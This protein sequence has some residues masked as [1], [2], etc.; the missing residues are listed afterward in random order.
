[1]GVSEG[2]AS[3]TGRS[4]TG[5]SETGRSETGASV[6]GISAA[7]AFAVLAAVAAG[8][9]TTVVDR[10]GE[11]YRSYGVWTS[12]QVSLRREGV[13]GSDEIAQAMRALREA[14]PGEIGGFDV[15]EVRDFATGAEHRPRYLGAT[16]LIEMQLG[17][18]GRVL[19]RPSGTEPK[20]KVYVDLMTAY[21]DSGD[22]IGAE[23]Q[24]AEEAAKTGQSLA[25]WLV[26]R[27]A[28]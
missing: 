23:A 8:D 18:T 12:A 20:L 2:A 21:P 3:E 15:T 4:A 11:L 7:V 5:V 27:M 26:R 28:G 1:M 25:D 19:A 13:D 17:A 9:G 22:W 16:N 6:D 14:T 24:L 10:L